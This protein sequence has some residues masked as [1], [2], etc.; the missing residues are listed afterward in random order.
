MMGP[1]SVLIAAVTQWLQP[2]VD[3][4]DLQTRPMDN[5]RSRLLESARR[6]ERDETW[7]LTDVRDGDTV[8]RAPPFSNFNILW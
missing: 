6:A 2:E 1:L 7:T 3:G 8:T 5:S 4:A